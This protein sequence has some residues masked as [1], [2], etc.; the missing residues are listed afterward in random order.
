[1]F[2]IVKQKNK[3]EKRVSD[4]TAHKDICSK[5]QEKQKSFVIEFPNIQRC[6]VDIFN[7]ILKH[8]NSQPVSYSWALVEFTFIIDRAAIN[9]RKV[10]DHTLGYLP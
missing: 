10:L 8:Y 4:K 5:V 9:A 3:K 1:M 6:W 2:P 7:E